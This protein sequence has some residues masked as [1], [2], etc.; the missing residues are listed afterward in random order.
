MR[1]IN[2]IKSLIFFLFFWHSILSQNYA[3]ED[4]TFLNK[5][6]TKSLYCTKMDEKNL[7]ILNEHMLA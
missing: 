7:M 2:K 1:L 5:N 6:L 4:H 3:F